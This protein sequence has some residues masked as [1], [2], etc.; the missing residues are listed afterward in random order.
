MLKHIKWDIG[1]WPK[2]RRYFFLIFIGALSSLAFAPLFLAPLLWI[3]LGGLIC[4]TQASAGFKQSVKEGWFWGFGHFL[5]SNYWIGSSFLVEADRFAWMIPFIL[6]GLASYLALFP[7]FACGLASFFK[8]RSIFIYW[9]A[10]GLSF[11][12]TEWLR[13]WVLTG[14]PWNL[15]AYIWGFSTYMM[16]PAAYIGSYGLS[17]L[18][19][20]LATLPILVM[21]RQ[22]ILGG[23]SLALLLILILLP[24]LRLKPTSWSA[25]EI[26]LVQPGLSQIERVQGGKEAEHLE[27]L[28]ELSASQPYS[29]SLRAIIWPEAAT[30]FLLE[31][32]PE[33]RAAI[34]EIVPENGYLLTGAVRADP[35]EGKISQIWN[36]LTA[37]NQNGNIA[38][39]YDKA[40]LVPL[41]EYVPGRKLLPFINKLTPGQIDFSAGLGAKTLTL[42]NLPPFSPLICYEIIF[43]GDITDHQERPSWLVNVTNDGWFGTTIG[44]YQHFVSA[45]FRAVEEGLPLIRVANTGISAVI[46]PYGQVVHSLS[47]GATGI[48]DSFIPESLPMTLYRRYLHFTLSLW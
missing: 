20:L 10:F 17:F 27:R 23:G 36:S 43:P 47:L 29:P 13:G 7:A 16:Q 39:T 34:A 2:R 45:R 25:T 12:F 46:D 9:L 4:F 5:A 1:Q 18:T 22:R 28:L 41:G 3:G 8:K 11:V 32:H 42:P 38:G 37:I 44:P 26:R 48:L 40:H 31:R 19:I 30:D 24:G 21:R 14:Y 15:T 6:G 35:A 33:I